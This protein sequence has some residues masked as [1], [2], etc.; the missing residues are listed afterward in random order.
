[1]IGTDYMIGV[2]EIIM[3]NGLRRQVRSLSIDCNDGDVSSLGL[4]L[5]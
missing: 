2:C 4:S 3:I 5:K 1:M